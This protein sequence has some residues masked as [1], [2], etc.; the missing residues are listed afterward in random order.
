MI[1]LFIF[2]TTSLVLLEK[3]Q[4]YKTPMEEFKLGT[5]ILIVGSRIYSLYNPYK[6]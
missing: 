5:D 1:I 6:Y 2:N 3:D 4:I